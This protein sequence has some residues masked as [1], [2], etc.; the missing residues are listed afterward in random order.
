MMKHI[1]SRML[2]LTVLTFSI[3]ILVA[4]GKV[5]GDDVKKDDSKTVVKDNSK[6]SNP[7]LDNSK[8]VNTGPDKIS[9][10][11]DIKSEGPKSFFGKL[12]GKSTK[13]AASGKSAPGSSRAKKSGKTKGK[14]SDTPLIV[15]EKKVKNQK[16]NIVKI[17]MMVDANN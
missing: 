14:T 6:D 7:S 4:Q 2:M 15:A 11:A 5:G 13:S 8:K 3:N 1:V 10:D 17:K 16:M 9:S 12:F